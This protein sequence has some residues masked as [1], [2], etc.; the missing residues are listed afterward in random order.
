MSQL[1]THGYLRDA[2]H[3]L[4]VQAVAFY[5]TK[6]DRCTVLTP[7]DL[8]RDFASGL[9][10]VQDGQDTPLVFDEDGEE[11]DNANFKYIRWEDIAAAMGL[12]IPDQ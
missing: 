2:L 12:V 8:G 5:M 11:I 10:V 3:P 7:L 9:L 4:G 1:L 6:V